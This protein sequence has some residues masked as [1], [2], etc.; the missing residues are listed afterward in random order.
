M[1]SVWF[2]C[3]VEVSRLENVSAVSSHE[4]TTL[5]F[6]VYATFNALLY[7]HLLFVTLHRF[8]YTF[9]LR[10]DSTACMKNVPLN[11]HIKRSKTSLERKK[12]KEIVF[13]SCLS[14]M[15][16]VFWTNKSAWHVVR[17]VYPKFHNKLS[18]LGHVKRNIR[19]LTVRKKMNSPIICYLNIWMKSM[20]WIFYC[21][22]IYE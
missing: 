20:R 2:E 16:F 21:P 4:I 6:K 9:T 17:Y 14:I 11:I 10:L 3:Y 18:K 15:W 5:H 19:I 13:W 22:P 8:D 12:N 1:R 7:I